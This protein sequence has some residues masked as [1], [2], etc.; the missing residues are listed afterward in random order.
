[1]R[2]RKS[3]RFSAPFTNFLATLNSYNEGFAFV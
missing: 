3:W 2:L 1:V